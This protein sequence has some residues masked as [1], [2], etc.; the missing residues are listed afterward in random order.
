MGFL[1]N[2]RYFLCRFL[3]PLLQESYASLSSNP[4]HNFHVFNDVSHDIIESP[5]QAEASVL[6]PNPSSLTD[7]APE[8]EHVQ[9]QNPRRQQSGSSGQ[10]SV[11]PINEPILDKTG[12]DKN[13]SRSRRMAQNRAAYVCHDLSMTFRCRDP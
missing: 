4:N 11:S 7:F 13:Y 8:A 5:H 10:K 2:S 1:F 6:D 9:Q 12:S 3:L